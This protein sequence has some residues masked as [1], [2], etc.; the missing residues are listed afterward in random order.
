[1]E[2]KKRGKR[3]KE[4]DERNERKISRRKRV[5]NISSHFAIR[6]LIA[7]SKKVLLVVGRNVWE[8][9]FQRPLDFL[10]NLSLFPLLIAENF[11]MEGEGG[12]REG[13]MKFPSN[14]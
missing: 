7:F 14:V 11:W 5:Y 4:K 6:Q 9:G 10:D 8:I 12:E 3:E 13:N 1:M 2:I